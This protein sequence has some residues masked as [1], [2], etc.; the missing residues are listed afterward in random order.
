MMSAAR[1]FAPDKLILAV[2]TGCFL[3]YVGYLALMFAGGHWI[4]D[5]NGHP[6][7]TDFVALWTAGRLALRDAALAAY[8]PRLRHAAQVAV[9]GHAFRGYFDW[10]YPPIFL[11]VVTPLAK[12]PYAGAFLVWVALSLA[13]Y[14]ASVG[15][16]AQQRTAA[17]V[18]LAAP[19]TFA[20]MQVGQTG[21]LSAALVATVLLNLERR[22]LLAGIVLG[23]VSYKPQFGLLFPFALA[24]GGYWRAFAWA[25]VSVVVAFLLCGVVFGTDT[26]A[27]FAS[28]LPESSKTLLTQGAVGWNKLQSFYGMTRWLGGT[29]AA[30]WT[31]QAI[32]TASVA[33]GVV[34]LWRSRADYNLKA[35]GL[36]AGALLATPYVFGHDMP[37]LAIGFAFLFR[38]RAFDAIEYLAMGAAILFFLAFAFLAIPVAFFASITLVVLIVRR[39]SSSQSR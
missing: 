34:A 25:S 29:N 15:A 35:A 37:I 24:A 22:S 21:F 3:G 2:A 33:A 11:F 23:L 32:I 17:M 20:V 7:A 8:D 13:A 39:L 36:C 4:I 6:Q 9:V 10:A 26:L 38:Q 1:D 27:A 28:Q 31:V 14:A 5:A 18:A 30:G 16:I 12:L 19:W